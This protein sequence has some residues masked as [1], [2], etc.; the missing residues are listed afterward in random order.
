MLKG[1]DRAWLR[2]LFGMRIMITKVDGPVGTYRRRTLRRL[3]GPHALPSDPLLSYGSTGIDADTISTGNDR[4]LLKVPLG[5]RVG[6][7]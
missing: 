7:M 5:G 3:V 1:R 4:Q 6:Y 2:V